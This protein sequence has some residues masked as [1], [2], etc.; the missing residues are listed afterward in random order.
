MLHLA[1]RNVY[2]GQAITVTSS[3]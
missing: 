2:I 3:K 1:N